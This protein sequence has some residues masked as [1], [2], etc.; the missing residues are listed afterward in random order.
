MGSALMQ[1]ELSSSTQGTGQQH[2]PSLSLANYISSLSAVACAVAR[3]GIV[4]EAI[5]EEDSLNA[6]THVNPALP[7]GIDQVAFG[8]FFSHFV[9]LA[10]LH[11]PPN[12]DCSRSCC[13]FQ[14]A[15]ATLLSCHQPTAGSC[16]CWARDML[17][18]EH[19]VHKSPGVPRASSSLESL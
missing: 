8:V 6:L 14:M 5:P 15:K 3:K 19:L 16:L 12:G 7:R 10:R 2:C 18:W 9:A 4:T 1:T 17:P 13:Q 11:E